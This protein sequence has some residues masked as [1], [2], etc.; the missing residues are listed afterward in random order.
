[1][2]DQE[3]DY[4]KCEYC[5]QARCTTGLDYLKFS[6]VHVTTTAYVL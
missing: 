1:M 2:L 4:V 5:L 3:L 6:M